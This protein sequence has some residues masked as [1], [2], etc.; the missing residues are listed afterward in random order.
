[1]EIELPFLLARRPD[2]TVVPVLIG[3]SDWPR[4]RTLG[5]ALAETVRAAGEPV[6]LVASS[7]MNHY[8]TAAEGGARTTLPSRPLARWTAKHCST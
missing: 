1:M 6:L 2:V 7:D 4:T 8:D 5:A 3:W